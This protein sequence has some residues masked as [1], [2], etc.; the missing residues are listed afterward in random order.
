[1]VLCLEDIVRFYAQMLCLVVIGMTGRCQN[2][3]VILSTINIF[4]INVG[5]LMAY[6]TFKKLVP[7]R[8]LI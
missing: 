4:Y 8:C 7:L 1:M 6:L 5:I 2:K 3:L